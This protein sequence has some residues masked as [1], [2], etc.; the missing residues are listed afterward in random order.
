MLRPTDAITLL[1][2]Y[3]ISPGIRPLTIQRLRPFHHYISISGPSIEASVTGGCGMFRLTFFT[4]GISAGFAA[5][6][7]YWERKSVQRPLPVKKAAAKLQEA[8]ADNHTRA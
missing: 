6:M 2:K 1:R 8:W 3:V 4:L 7:A 5:C